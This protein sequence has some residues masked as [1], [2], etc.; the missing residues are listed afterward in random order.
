MSE[1]VW[2]S[3]D[4]KWAY[5]GHRNA[6]IAGLILVILDIAGILL[7]P[8]RP[9][10]ITFSIAL[11]LGIVLIVHGASRINS[12]K[13]TAAGIKSIEVRNGSIVINTVNGTQRA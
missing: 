1:W 10:V 4:V 7:W 5:R 13:S 3:E 11:V 6:I 2:T 9:T 12:I 8:Y